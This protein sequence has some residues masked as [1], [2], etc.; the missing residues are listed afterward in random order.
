MKNYNILVLPAGTEIG[1]E[2]HR[3]LAACKDITLF[4]ANTS[5]PNHAP[6]VFERFAT[7][8]SIHEKNWVGALNKVL[9]K[10][11]I[12]Y[13]YPAYDDVLLALKNHE[14]RLAAPVIA[15]PLE[16]C[17]LTRSKKL[18]YQL[19]KGV[20]PTPT[21]YKTLR[22]IKY[23]PVFMKPEAGQGSQ[24]TWLCHSAVEAKLHRRKN[25]ALLAMEYLPGNEYTID[26][27][28]DNSGRLLFAG[29]RHR[30]RMREG[31]AVDARLVKNPLFRAYAQRIAKKLLL[32]GAWF[33]QVKENMAGQ[34]VL[35][36]IAPRISGTMA[37]SRVRGLNFPLLSIYQTAGLHTSLL[38]NPYS[39]AI[40]RALTNRYKT[41]LQ[42]KRVYVDLD[43]TL[44]F[45]N[46]VN[47]Q[48]LALLY[49]MRNNRK[50]L[51]LI[52]KHA[53]DLS[54]TLQ[55]YAIASSLFKRIIH[56][57]RHDR[58]HAAINPHQAIFID[59]SFGE[60]AAVAEQYR[61]PTF[62]C[63]MI[64]MLFNDRI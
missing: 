35:L 41:N 51:H 1:L 64:E 22:E 15:S 63:S 21:V 36:E 24:D 45:K 19:L 40:N 44:I 62:D 14:R 6:F 34:L 37:L 54:Q 60:R 16:T 55:R 46:K 11:R 47:T 59:D 4:G 9:R 8:P 7:L 31:V 49:Q 56:L 30:V 5:I 43:D 48:L 53:G 32:T 26:C 12:D 3:A 29:G 25:P 10:W 38:L 18:T 13:I 42:Y 39:V 50:E 27:F 57:Q 52:T 33:F 17:R 28:S 2:I 20:V 61:I 58:K 23:Y